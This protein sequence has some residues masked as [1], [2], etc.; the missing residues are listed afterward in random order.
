M[1][2]VVSTL[3]EAA[4]AARTSTTYEEI[5]HGDR[6]TVRGGRT[7]VTGSN[8]WPPPEPGTHAGS[9]CTHW[10]PDGE[11]CCKCLELVP[12]EA[13]WMPWCLPDRVARA[14]TNRKENT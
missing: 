11:R 3:L 9:H 13:T 5:Q 14:I 12:D 4:A 2:D 1:G 10:T 7:I 6:W 8:H